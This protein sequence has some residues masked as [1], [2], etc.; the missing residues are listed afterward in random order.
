MCCGFSVYCVVLTPMIESR[1]I[2]W[3]LSLWVILLCSLWK[4]RWKEEGVGLAKS[5]KGHKPIGRK[6]VQHETGLTL[7][8]VRNKRDEAGIQSA[9][10]FLFIQGV[11][12]MHDA[13]H[14]HV[15]PL[16][17]FRKGLIQ[18]KRN[19]FTRKLS[20]ISLCV[21]WLSHSLETDD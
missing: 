11:Q 1:V 8:S 10:S 7:P 13:T 15:C 17:L 4:N 18:G 3:A 14:F 12:L 20:Q 5:V 6:A 19:S 21:L 9:L 2:G 16:H